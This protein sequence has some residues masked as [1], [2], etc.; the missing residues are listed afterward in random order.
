M[1]CLSNCQRQVWDSAAVYTEV[2][3]PGVSGK[4][5]GETYGEERSS[6]GGV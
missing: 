4:A 3:G 6:G 1:N 5:D 2:F